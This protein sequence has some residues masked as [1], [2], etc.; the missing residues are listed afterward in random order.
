M[1]TGAHAVVGVVGDEVVGDVGT[2]CAEEV[3]PV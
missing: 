1:V 2:P 3:R